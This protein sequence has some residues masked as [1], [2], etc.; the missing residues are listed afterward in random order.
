MIEARVAALDTRGGFRIEFDGINKT[1]EV[2]VPVTGGWQ[3][4]ETVSATVILPAGT[5]VMRF[6]PTTSDFNVNYFE[7]L[8][9]TTPVLPDLRSPGATLHPC[10]P[11]PFN[12]STTISYELTDPAVVNL[13]VYDVAGQLV[14][15]LVA[16]ETSGAGRHEVVWNGRDETGRNVAAGV[17]FY[18]LDAGG[19]SETRRMALVK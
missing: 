5:Q 2:I 4:W 3:T 17:Y 1:G 14:R 11:N 7:I 15:T 8:A 19:Y 18:R 16:A 9:D 13:T 6:V 12:P 10:Y